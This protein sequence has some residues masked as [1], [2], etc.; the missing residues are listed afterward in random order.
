MIHIHAPAPIYLD[1]RRMPCPDCK[2]NAFFAG[3][4]F[5]WY[6]WDTTCLSCGREWK[7]GEWMPLPFVRQARQKNIDAAKRR[8]R[9][10]RKEQFMVQSD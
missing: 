6:G 9:K 7:S 3:L 8:W 2:R 1:I 5:E 4:L 10:Y